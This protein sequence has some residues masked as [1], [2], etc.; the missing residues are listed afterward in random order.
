MPIS[1]FRYH[2]DWKDQ[3]RPEALKRAKYACQKCHAPNRANVIF[4]T[5]TTYLTVDRYMLADIRKHGQKVVRVILTIAH[6]NH[7]VFDN[8]PDNLRALCQ[9]CH[10]NHDRAHKQE[11]QRLVKITRYETLIDKLCTPGAENALP[12]VYT[13]YR[14][15][16]K[17]AIHYH[18]IA[19][20]T[21]GPIYNSP[22]HKTCLDQANMYLERSRYLLSW[23]C[24]TLALHYAITDRLDFFRT[25]YD[26]EFK[27]IGS[28]DPSQVL[29]CG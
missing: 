25:Y 24:E 15:Y 1:Y 16:R 27:L 26:S 9:R 5:P 28:A 19:H 11:M 23:I 14:A 3:I 6:L 8:H 29:Y 20:N 7:L 13:V 17:K 4:D 10:L 21:S 18:N 12:H 22:D 2:P